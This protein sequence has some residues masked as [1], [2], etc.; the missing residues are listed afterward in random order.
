V[1]PLGAFVPGDAES[2]AQHLAA[3]PPVSN[4]AT[5]AVT[6]RVRWVLVIFLVLVWVYSGIHAQN[7]LRAGIKSVSQLILGVRYVIRPFVQDNLRAD[8]S[9]FAVQ[10][11]SR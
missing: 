1:S 3:M 11:P 10:Q 9:R 8:N 2:S 7:H 6:R 5:A 4:P